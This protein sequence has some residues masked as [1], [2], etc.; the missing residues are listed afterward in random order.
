MNIIF[1]GTPEIAAQCL[2]ALLQSPHQVTAIYTQPDRPAG[3]GKKLMPSP[4]KEIAQEHGIPVYQPEKLK[5]LDQTC[6]LMV[7]VAYGLIL[8]QAV[9][10]APKYGCI[11]VH[12]SLLPKYRGAAPMQAAILNG[13]KI[14]GVSVMQLDKGCD[15]GPVLLQQTCAITPSDTSETLLHT[16]TALGAQALLETLDKIEQ[17]TAVAQPQ[18]SSQASYAPKL[19]KEHG[20]LD[21]SL[22]AEILDRKI[23][24]YQ[25]WPLAYSFLDGER[26]NILEAKLSTDPVQAEPGTILSVN[27]Q[28]LVVATGQGTLSIQ[29]L[30]LPGKKAMPLAAILN[31]HPN[32]FK[33]GMHFDVAP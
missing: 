6:D 12:T 5:A 18:D 23:R 13:D 25:P 10:S 19:E 32:L 17:G 20:H 3:R 24:A 2:K 15:T 26:I 9:L 11:N 8:P 14:T 31:G 22:P 1:A 16:L 33:N 7:V 4:V 29:V 27:K 28:G 30:Q 21:W